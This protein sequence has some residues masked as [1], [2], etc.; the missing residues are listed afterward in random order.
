MSD[1]KLAAT[2][3]RYG[4]QN[5]YD[6]RP[7]LFGPEF[8]AS[9]MANPLFSRPAPVLGDAPYREL[10]LLIQGTQ[11]LQLR[12][13]IDVLVSRCESPIE[14]LMALALWAAGLAQ[15]DAVKMADSMREFDAFGSLA[16]QPQYTI[17]R[18][19][20]DFLVTYGHMNYSATEPTPK[21]SWRVCRAV[22]EC[23]GHDYHERTKEQAK[24]DRTRDRDMQASG[25]KVYRYTG[26]E[27]WAD[28]LKCALEV[29]G[30]LRDDAEKSPIIA[31]RAEK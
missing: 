9:K 2:I 16:I 6:A 13:E 10:M 21:L 22:V 20:A 26:A 27:L 12:G 19:R 17:G 28:P 14:E 31:E 11:F 5:L 25:W 4:A 7:R 3:A 18:Y 15:C 29:V 30:R 1:E 23:D 24:Y 8:A